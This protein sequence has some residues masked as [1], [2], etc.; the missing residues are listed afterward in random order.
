MGGAR[1]ARPAP[2]A[3]DHRRR[4][5][6]IAH[7]H[8]VDARAELLDFTT[9]LVTEDHGRGAARAARGDRLQLG[10]ANADGGH[11]KHD[12]ARGG[13]RAGDVADLQRVPGR[14]D[15]RLHAL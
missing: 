14:V 10:A 8:V 9:E 1:P 13:A 5:D 15:E 2:S 4:G 12:V 7:L 3:R 11:A 6:A